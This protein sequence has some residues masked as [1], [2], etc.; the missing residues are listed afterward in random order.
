M[1]ERH[2]E[3]F[4]KLVH[5]ATG[6]TIDYWGRGGNPKRARRAGE[7]VAQ[8][9]HPDHILNRLLVIT[10][11]MRNPMHP[12]R[13]TT[14]KNDASLVQQTAREDLQRRVVLRPGLLD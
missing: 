2:H 13:K 9:Q 8:R 5:R 4:R 12:T 11:A 6:I 3:Q 14:S 10:N 7:L 1:V